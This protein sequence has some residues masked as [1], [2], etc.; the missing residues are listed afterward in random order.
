MDKYFANICL[1]EMPYIRDDSKKVEDL[2]KETI[3]KTGEN[4]R[5]K[6]FTRYALGS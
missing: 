4:I 1:M 5:V 2:V 6:R 3:A